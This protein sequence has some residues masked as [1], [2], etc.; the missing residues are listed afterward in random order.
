MDAKLF[1]N[2][3]AGVLRH[4]LYPSGD[5]VYAT[6]TNVIKFAVPLF[7]REA[8]PISQ[9]LNR[10]IQVAAQAEMAISKASNTV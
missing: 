6:D 2:Y 1:T 8:A 3:V 4:H 9:Q 10:K 7:S 5:A